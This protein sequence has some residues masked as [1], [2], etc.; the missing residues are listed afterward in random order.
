ME[1]FYQE[2]IIE[3]EQEETGERTFIAELDQDQFGQLDI[4]HLFGK[5]K[6]ENIQ[7]MLSKATGLAFVTVD[8]KGEPITESTSFSR[9][10]STIRNN[11]EIAMCCK[12]SDAFGAIQAAVTQKPSVYFCPC[13][14]LEVA[15]PIVLKGHYLGGFIGGQ[16]R[17]NDA[18]EEVSQLK[19]V[20][21]SPAKNLSQEDQDSLLSE[22]PVYS[23]EKFQDIANLV[24]LIIN[25]LSENEVN[26]HMQEEIFQKKIRK[27]YSSNQ[28]LAVE[29]KQR[30]EELQ[31]LKF[32]NNPF[33]MLDILTSLVSLSVVEQAVKTNEM[34]LQFTEYIRYTYLEKGMFTPISK[35]AEHAEQYLMMQKQKFRERLEYSIKIPQSLGMQKIPDGVLMPF[36]EQAVF[37]GIM[38]KKEGGHIDISGQLCNGKVMLTIEDNGLGLSDEEEEIRFEAFGKDYEGYYI[39]LGMNSARQKMKKIFKDEFEI[40]VECKKGSGRKCTIIWPEHFSERI[41][42]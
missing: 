4:I 32:R 14:L 10:C 16:I 25:Q 15:I 35:E 8:Y 37:F 34:L 30:E 12:A 1:Q 19:K 23:Y 3:K 31:E 9:F 42:S 40:I 24:F 7:K 36:V 41:D 38:Q 28:K 27:I 39:R 22:I 2:E 6:L 11:Q 21:P 33:F 13:G 26:S 17:C 5:E 18:P 29:L 20:M